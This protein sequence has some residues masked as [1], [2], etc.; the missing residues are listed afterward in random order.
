MGR[1]CKRQRSHK[2][3]LNGREVSRKQFLQRRCG[4][5]GVAMGV[6]AYTGAQPLQSLAM[7][8]HRTQVE[9][10]NAEARRQGLTGISW[11]PDGTC[12]ITSRR[13]R[14]KWLRSQKQ[15]DDDGGYGD[16]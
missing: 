16:G 2:L 6:A 15:H 3:L 13:D 11:G 9:E 14:A 4:G 1:Q 7:S 5:E 8:C 10:Y 12:E